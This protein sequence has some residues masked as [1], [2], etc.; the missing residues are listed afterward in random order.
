M[1]STLFGPAYD[2]SDYA[3]KITTWASKNG[4]FLKIFV[5]RFSG[6]ELSFQ[7]LDKKN[8][9]ANRPYYGGLYAIYLFEQGKPSKCLYVGTS[10]NNMSY[11][12]YRFLKELLNISRHD[13]THPAATKA[14]LDGITVEDDLRVMFF[15]WDQLP[16]P[17]GD[18]ET[19]CIYDEKRL[20]EY[21]A[22]YL[23]SEYNVVVR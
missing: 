4:E 1:I 9:I 19:E 23:K 22:K 20:D 8:S 14:R 15:S 7:L 16:N 18:T 21:V 17:P 2:G 11:R 12:I 6:N 10:S 5:D 3:R 13:E